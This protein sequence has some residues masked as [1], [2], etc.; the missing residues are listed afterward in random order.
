MSRYQPPGVIGPIHHLLSGKNP[1]ALRIYNLPR[2]IW[3]YL[4][5]A[6]AEA[7]PFVFDFHELDSDN[8][9][10]VAQF[11]ADL[12]CRG[13][14]QAP[15][16][17]TLLQWPDAN[18]KSAMW[19]YAAALCITLQRSSVRTRWTMPLLLPLLPEARTVEPH[20]PHPNMMLVIGFAIGP[21]GGNPN[22]GFWPDD[23]AILQDMF[24]MSSWD[25]G[26]HLAIDG[27]GGKP[28]PESDK[29]V[30]A[31]SPFKKGLGAEKSAQ[32]DAGVTFRNLLYYMGVLSSRGAVA[33]TMTPDHRIAQK[34]REQNRS[35]WSEYKIIS[36]PH[37]SANGTHGTSQG[38]RSSPRLHWRRGHVRRLSEER[39]TTVSPC[40]VGSSEL[41][42]VIASYHVER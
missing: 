31:Y 3:T 28:I 5:A 21:I 8:G 39:I 29:H 4:S 38:E 24:T 15:F 26:V 14:L 16:D 19:R 27:P 17:V 32:I 20:I 6:L 41:G 7:H 13:M 30:S 11:T 42:S 9:A 34:R 18:S 2:P 10:P 36:L 12:M 1:D 35:P 40:L 37:A 22:K 25:S 23:T 33:Q